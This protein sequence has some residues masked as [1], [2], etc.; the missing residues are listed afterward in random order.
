MVQ[1]R[2]G[3]FRGVSAGLR[4]CVTCIAILSILG[5]CA[6]CHLLAQSN[7]PETPPPTKAAP[8]TKVV[9]LGELVPQ[10]DVITVA[11]A[12]DS[13]VNHILLKEGDSDIA[14]ACVSSRR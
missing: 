3:S 4:Q 1:P 9:A 10:G 8:S 11:N 12:Q 13:R 5:F 2:C 14:L 6:V 7:I